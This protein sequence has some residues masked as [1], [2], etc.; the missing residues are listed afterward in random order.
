MHSYPNTSFCIHNWSDI[1]Q[2]MLSFFLIET[3]KI[4][5]IIILRSNQS[6]QSIFFASTII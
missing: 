6:K 5:K 1:K 3:R 2:E 4:N